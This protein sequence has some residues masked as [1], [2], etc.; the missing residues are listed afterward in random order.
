MGSTFEDSDQSLN[1]LMAKPVSNVQEPFNVDEMETQVGKALLYTFPSRH[2]LETPMPTQVTCKENVLAKIN[3]EHL[4]SEDLPSQTLFYDFP[5]KKELKMNNCENCH[6]VTHD[7]CILPETFTDEQRTKNTNLNINTDKDDEIEPC[8]VGDNLE[9]KRIRLD[10]NSSEIKTPLTDK[11]CCD[12]KVCNLAARPIE[13]KISSLNVIE[14]DLPNCKEIKSSLTLNSKTIATEFME[15]SSESE[16]ENESQ[17]LTPIVFRKKK[18]ATVDAKIDLTKKFIDSLPVRVI[19]RFRKPTIKL[20]GVEG[21]ANKLIPNILKPRHLIES[22]NDMNQEIICENISR[23][24]SFINK[25][26]YSNGVEILKDSNCNTEK[27]EA[28]HNNKRYKKP[29]LKVDDHQVEKVSMSKSSRRK[30]LPYKVIKSVNVIVASSKRSTRSTR[31]GLTS[32][33]SVNIKSV[34]L[35]LSQPKIQKSFKNDSNNFVKPA[36]KTISIQP[37]NKS[38]YSKVVEIMKVNNCN[39]KKHDSKQKN[40]KSKNTAKVDDFQVEKF[41]I[42]K[43]IRYKP[44]LHKVTKSVNVTIEPSRRSTRG[45]RKRQTSDK[46]LEIK[47]VSLNNDKDRKE[48]SKSN[49]RRSRRYIQKEENK[50]HSLS[51]VKGIHRSSRLISYKEKKE[52]NFL[53]KK[54]Q[55]PGNRILLSPVVLLHRITIPPKKSTP[56]KSVALEESTMYSILSDSGPDTPK[57]LKRPACLSLS[58]PNPKR[59]RSTVSSN[60]S[61]VQAAPARSLKTQH[62]FFKAQLSSNAVKTKI[63]ELGK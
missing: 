11:K 43:S 9:L 25:K 47:S 1:D 20:Q 52:N 41:S 57:N 16:S 12:Q 26:K 33:K 5:G 61:R 45:T 28:K 30:A 21:K 55:L 63:K 48:E 40:K 39:T 35:P 32:D 14:I 46:A 23:L 60:I 2:C 27:H 53:L 29:T 36:V 15:S 56:V 17:E 51:V 37:R 54:S 34:S 49:E 50:R 7:I 13:K 44:M 24:K 62:V 4:N 3:V 58:G 31:K 10:G 19:T 22:E 38:K 59:T 42:S 8:S 18:K 6:A